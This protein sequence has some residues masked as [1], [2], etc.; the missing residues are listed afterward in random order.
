MTGLFG[1]SKPILAMLHLKGE[2]P[3]DVL[4]R[5]M[6]ETDILVSNGVDAL[7]VENYFG[8][9]ADVETV[10]ATLAAESLPVPYGINVLDDGPA[11][12]ALADTYGAA[13]VQ[14]DSVAGHLPADQDP[15]FAR[16]PRGPSGE[17]FGAAPRRRA[18]Q[19][20]AGAV[21]KPAGRRPAPGQPAL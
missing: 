3:R 1:I 14:M 21:R 16:V 18:V 15:G 19:V 7:V 8:S 10:L 12:F 6:Q 9:R 11:S 5:A 4:N 20:P 17:E 2:D 13:F